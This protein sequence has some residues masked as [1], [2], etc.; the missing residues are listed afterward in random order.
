[1]AKTFSWQG[2]KKKKKSIDNAIEIYDVCLMLIAFYC[3]LN[4]PM[5][6]FFKKKFM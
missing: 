3:R 4:T 5:S 2:F 1:M 6:F